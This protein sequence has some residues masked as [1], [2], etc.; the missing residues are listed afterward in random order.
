MKWTIARRI[1][2]ALAIELGL[3]AVIALIGS[4]ALKNTATDYERAMAL[5]RG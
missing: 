5:R 3:V 4:S 1:T 2:L